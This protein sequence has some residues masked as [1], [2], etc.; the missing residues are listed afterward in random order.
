MK[1]TPGTLAYAAQ[2]EQER[3]AYWDRE[4]ARQQRLIALE[5]ARECWQC[6]GTTEGSAINWICDTCRMSRGNAS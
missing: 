4:Q 5:A 2:A 1:L 3:T 6:H